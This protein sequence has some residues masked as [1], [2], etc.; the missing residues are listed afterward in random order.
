MRLFKKKHF[1][2]KDEKLEKVFEEGL[3][4]QIEKGYGTLKK[5]KID[6]TS[7]DS[8]EIIKKISFPNHFKEIYYVKEGA[9]K[10]RII[11]VNP[12]FTY[13]HEIYLRN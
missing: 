3:L 10:Y 4:P 5:L 9:L 2:E 1:S 8:N 7:N 6:L 13:L 11:K 12:T